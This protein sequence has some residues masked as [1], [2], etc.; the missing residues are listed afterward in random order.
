[1]VILKGL[2]KNPKC[3]VPSNIYLITSKGGTMNEQLM[4]NWIEN[5]F[6]A[7]GPFA[8]AKKNL[9][10]LDHFGSHKKDAVTRRLS[11]YNTQI[12]LIP[13]KTTHYLQPLDVAIN[14]V[15]KNA[16]KNQWLKWFTEGEKLFTL[17]GYRK[18]PNWSTV[19][20]MVSDSI[21]E[22]KNTTIIKSFKCCGIAAF[23]EKVNFQVLNNKLQS[24]LSEDK[25]ETE[26][27]IE[28][29]DES[30]NEENLHLE[31]GEDVSDLESDFDELNL[32]DNN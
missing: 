9:L 8:S 27:P 26:K 18:K 29:S 32:S 11:Q 3:N 21:K 25:I 6:I 28:E 19:L 15:F 22:I 12:Q 4:L 14:S 13:K 23:G 24:I 2:K 1:M 30:E 16:F 20:Q 31:E 10:F 17:S 7:R 5:C